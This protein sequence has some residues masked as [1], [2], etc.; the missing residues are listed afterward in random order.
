VKKKPIPCPVC[1]RKPNGVAPMGENDFWE[2]SHVECP[3]RHKVTAAPSDRLPDP[4][5]N[6]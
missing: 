4:K 1:N 6:P 2:C 5:E 3:N